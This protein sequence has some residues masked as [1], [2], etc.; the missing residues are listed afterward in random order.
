M[1][2]FE[3]TWKNFQKNEKESTPIVELLALLL[4]LYFFGSLVSYW[5]FLD[6]DVPYSAFWHA[7]WMWIVKIFF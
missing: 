4:I 6:G 3:L 1:S 7:P 5:Q 2:K